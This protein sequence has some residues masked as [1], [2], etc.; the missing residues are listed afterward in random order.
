MVKRRKGLRVMLA[1]LA[2]C[3]LAGCSDGEVSSEKDTSP[4]QQE[5]QQQAETPTAPEAEEEEE[6][7]MLN[8]SVGGYEFQAVWEDNPSAQEFKELLAQGPI[9]ISM[10]DYGGFEKVGPLGTEITPS[11]QSITTEPG[12]VILYQ[13]DQITIYYGTNSWNFTRL[14]KIQ[15]VEHLKEALGQGS[16]QVTFSLGEK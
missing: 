12:D 9:T 7:T 6:E 3:A 10:K 15:N 11:D 1:L 8:I 16:V 14:A 4:S 2:M 5:V 13:G